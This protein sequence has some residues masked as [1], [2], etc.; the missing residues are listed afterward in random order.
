MATNARLLIV[1]DE[2]ANVRLLERLLGYAGYTELRSITDPRDTVRLF[3][4]FAPD[5]VL[6][7]LAMPH[8]D[9]YA[10][11]E[12]L[13]P[14]VP[15][16]AYLPILVLTADATP[17]ARRRA[18]AMGAKDFL[19]KPLDATEVLLRIAN[20]LETRRLTL[21]LQHQNE[22]LEEQVRERTERLLQTE[23]VAT[24]GSLLAGVAHELNNPLTIITGWTTLLGRSLPPGRAA[25]QVERIGTAAARC[26]RIIKNFLALARRW[27]PE[28]G[29]VDLNTMVR[30]T[31]EFLAYELRVADVEVQI[32][33]AED[34]PL[35]WAD[36]HQIQQVLVN[37]AINAHQAMRD[38]P[39]PRALAITT[40]FDRAQQRVHLVVSDSGPGVAPDL[41][42]RIFEPFF[43]TKPLTS[44]TGLG[45]SL[46]QSIVESHGG[47]I[48]LD[49]RL[50]T[51]ATFT[52]ELPLGTP[53][54]A[55]PAAGQRDELAP[56]RG[57]K[58][59][60]VDDEEEIA[61]MLAEMLTSEGHDVMTADNG[62]TALDKLR[63]QVYDVIV[64][65]SGMPHLDGPG[66]YREVERLYPRLVRRFLFLSGD[67]L[68]PKTSEFMDRVGARRINKPFTLEQVRDGVRRLLSESPP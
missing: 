10:V 31:V 22:R 38:V 40:H 61:T 67:T 35:L 32:E 41:Q 44:G 1:D 58:V 30:E 26:V 15:E 65:D 63:E 33:L 42:T 14:L 3:E 37:L 62:L 4:E 66:L 57:L 43:T 27:P 68:N 2:P 46:C 34:V 54:L 13:A 52:V 48:R 25:G 12:A 45:L 28:R 36:P 53:T 20:L 9:G 51:G 7:D 24:L 23:K 21:A 16:G 8:L 47:T 18:L 11:M 17:D 19:T 55:E 5:L 6:L 59:L 49:S 50:G 60:L 64:C 39:P 29:P 56:V